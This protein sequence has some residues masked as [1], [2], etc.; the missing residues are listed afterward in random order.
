MD[1][2]IA[3][4]AP[5]I[6]NAYSAQLVWSIQSES[7]ETGYGIVTYT[8][9]AAGDKGGHEYI[10]NKIISD[11]KAGAVIIIA[12]S[13][14]EKII[15]GFKNAGITPVLIDTRWDG[16]SC[17]RVDNEKGG[18]EAGGH[19]V[20]IGKKRIGIITGNLP[21]D[22]TQ[23]ERLSGF[24]KGIHDNGIE[25]NED[26][27]W[28]SND[29]SYA[30]GKEALRVMIMNDADGVFCAAGDYVA[31]GFLNE[32]RKNGVEIPLHMA[33]VGFD[34]IETSVDFGLTTVRQPLNEIGKEA[35]KIA[36]EAISGRSTG[37]RET[38]FDCR[39][40]LRDTA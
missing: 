17:V 16:I 29:Y 26:L 30:S 20:K 37:P 25:F 5:N 28:R 21:H 19:L 2:L 14:N 11:K 9:N 38:V 4:V 7:F 24:K 39:L 35:F 8:A 34:D 3:V 13:V 12:C 33:I 23:R 18:Y 27:T 1:N 40:V 22:N 6:L 10:F 15:N 31:Q 36:V 32:A